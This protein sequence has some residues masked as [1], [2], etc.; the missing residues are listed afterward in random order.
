MALTVVSRYRV[1]EHGTAEFLALAGPA[2]GALAA[3][4][5][6]LAGELCGALDDGTLFA[7]VTR[8]ESVGSYRRAL[9]HYDVKVTAVPLMYRAIDEPSAFEP[10]L[11]ADDG[12]VVVRERD[13]ADDVRF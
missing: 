1:V 3:R 4:P 5:G 13:R 10:V 9:S 6:F 12:Q 8:W 7:L 2:L 11:V